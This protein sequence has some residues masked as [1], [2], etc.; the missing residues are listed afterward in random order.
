[1]EE[2]SLH[3]LV[4]HSSKQC[5]QRTAA[6]YLRSLAP[7]TGEA[8]P[9]PEL[10]TLTGHP[11]HPG[12]PGPRGTGVWVCGSD[13]HE[14]AANTSVHTVCIAHSTETAETTE[15]CKPCFSFPHNRA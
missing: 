4:A 1:M 7:M 10:R 8:R 15:T 5:I 2:S 11:G 6:I 14:H 12:H 3:R 9:G 13:E